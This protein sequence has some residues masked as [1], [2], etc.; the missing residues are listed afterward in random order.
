M[1]ALAFHLIDGT[2]AK[3]D[4]HPSRLA[5]LGHQ[6]SGRRNG[7]SVATCATCAATTLAITALAAAIAALAATIGA[8]ADQATQATALIAATSA[9]AARQE[10]RKH[11]CRNVSS[12]KHSYGNSFFEIEEKPPPHA[13]RTSLPGSADDRVRPL[14]APQARPPL[15]NDALR[16]GAAIFAGKNVFDYAEE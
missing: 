9:T 13:A 16:D 3:S 14:A 15:Q 8:Q 11:Q 6:R 12:G 1:N 4:Q 7:R 5:E 10:H 2:G